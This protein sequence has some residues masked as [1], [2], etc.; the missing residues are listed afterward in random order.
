MPNIC[1]KNVYIQRIN[2]CISGGLL[3]TI[4]IKQIVNIINWWL[5]QF[6]KVFM[7]VLYKLF[8][9]TLKQLF[10]LLNKSFTHNPQHLLIRLIKEN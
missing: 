7:P 2:R 4:Q 1:V 3:S 5:T 10:N 9:T 8:S 6:I